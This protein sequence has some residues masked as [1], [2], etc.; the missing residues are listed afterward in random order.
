MLFP[1]CSAGIIR[2]VKAI[3]GLTDLLLTSLAFFAAY[4]DPHPPAISRR[5]SISIFR[6]TALLLVLSALCWVAIGYWF[7]IYEK[8]DSAHPR[9]VL[10]D[11]FRQ[12]ALGGDFAGG[13]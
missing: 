13:G 11:T 3:F 9:V 10:R 2:K 8:L 7:N 12:C 6:L 4:R 5:F 1:E